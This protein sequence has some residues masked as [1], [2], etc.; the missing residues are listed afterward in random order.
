MLQK[1]RSVKTAYQKELNKQLD[2]MR[3]AKETAELELQRALKDLSVTRATHLD[4]TKELDTSKR[5]ETS[6]HS[7][8]VNQ[9]HELNLERTK[10]Y[11]KRSLHQQALQKQQLQLDQLAKYTSDLKAQG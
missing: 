6:Q 9:I 4:L 5:Y 7:E 11:H 2:D 8:L 10:L 1:V 3:K